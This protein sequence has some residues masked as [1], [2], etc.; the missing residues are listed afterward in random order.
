MSDDPTKD[1][2]ADGGQSGAEGELAPDRPT[3][4]AEDTGT[5]VQ[6]EEAREQAAQS[7]V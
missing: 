3:D 6:Q 7:D 1:A 2:G 4:D 5:A